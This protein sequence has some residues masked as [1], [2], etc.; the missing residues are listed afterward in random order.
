MSARR[1]YRALL[2]AY[3]STFRR[4]TGDEMTWVFEQRLA[5][6]RSRGRGA[7]AGLWARTLADL[8]RN[9]PPER[10]LTAR[11]AWRRRGTGPQPPAR[12]ENMEIFRQDLRYAWRAL[13]ERP[14]FTAVAV[15][16]LALGVGGNTAV[17]SIVNAM[18]LRPLPFP[19]PDRIVMAWV[20]TQAQPQSA[21][22]YPEYEDW[23]AQARSFEDMAVWRGQSVN[24][25]GDGEPERLVGNYDS[26]NIFTLLGAHAAHGRTFLPGETTPGAAK[27]VA[28]LS[29]AVWQRRFGGDPG[30]VGRTLT[31]NGNVHTVVGVLGPQFAPR[32]APTE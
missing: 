3:P 13:R 15:L 2:R 12:R 31:V 8:A 10:W 30:V 9:A 14:G 24:L 16:T 29:H 11:A 21:A 4:E 22:S 17:F 27:P 28:V 5:H 25:T 26:V 20:K 1:L 18:L 19:N 7:V 23:R 6:E 32:R